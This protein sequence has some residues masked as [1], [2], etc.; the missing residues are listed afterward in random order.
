MADDHLDHPYAALNLFGSDD[1][2]DVL[3]HDS[4]ADSS[5]L[6][7]FT[8]SP[9]KVLVHENT[10]VSMDIMRDLSHK[11][12]DDTDRSCMS[13]NNIGDT[14]VDREKNH[15]LLVDKSGETSDILKKNDEVDGVLTNFENKN[16][17]A[18]QS[19]TKAADHEEDSKSAVQTD[20]ESESLSRNVENQESE[21]AGV[22]PNGNEPDHLEESMSGSD[23]NTA[24]TIDSDD[25]EKD[26]S[27]DKDLEND[28][29]FN[30]LSK[31]D[32]E[33]SDVERQGATEGD[34]L[35]EKDIENG[36]E[37]TSVK[38][39]N[40]GK[41]SKEENTANESYEDMET[42][43]ND[44][45]ETDE[46]EDIQ[47]LDTSND[48]VP[49]DS[50]VSVRTTEKGHLVLSINRKKGRKR[51]RK[52]LLWTRPSPY[53]AQRLSTESLKKEKAVNNEEVD[54]VGTSTADLDDTTE[55]TKG[56]VS[57]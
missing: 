12:L 19:L 9:R 36:I 6:K 53:K 45:E 32:L 5:P 4:S 20:S 27:N 34:V 22:V 47:M 21:K 30:S 48:G 10:D 44:G 54:E 56:N 8:D 24:K 26:L 57:V 7:A 11:L 2:S 46:L 41:E 50:D 31:D 25:K 16:N 3:P 23:E 17:N 15:G 49:A 55:D 13:D 14:A 28:D 39:S 37:S 51:K 40:E 1:Y 18:S 38:E 42:S 43:V 35:N 29:E 33:K 52:S